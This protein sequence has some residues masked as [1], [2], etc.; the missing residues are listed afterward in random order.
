MLKKLV[1]IP[2]YNEEKSIKDV[3][4][5]LEKLTTGYDYIVVNDG[6]RDN[7]EQVC[8]QNNLKYISLPLNLGIGGAV[9]TGYKYAKENNYDVAIQIDGDGQHDVTY[10]DRLIEGLDD[11]V[12]MCIGSRYIDK[13]GFQSSFM[14]RMGKNVISVWMKILCGKTI[15]D[16]TSGF[17]ACNRRVIEIFAKDY[18]YDYPEPETIVKLVSNKFTVKEVPVIMRE[19]Q[20]GK[21]SITPVKSLKFMIKVILSMFFARL[22]RRGIK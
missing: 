10:L 17:R 2:A 19:R 14:R 16:P 15:T 1:I 4:E 13:E 9:Q 6:S 3:V 7:T 22:N 20:G 8:K 11:G 5:N 12:D 21:S 18:P